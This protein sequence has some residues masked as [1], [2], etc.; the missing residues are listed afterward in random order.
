MKQVSNLKIE[1][2]K[3]ILETSERSGF[4]NSLTFKLSVIIVLSKVKKYF[5][6][7]YGDEK[8]TLLGKKISKLLLNEEWTID[9][10]FKFVKKIRRRNWQFKEFDKVI[11]WILSYNLTDSSEVDSIT[12]NFIISK[13]NPH[14][15][16][17]YLHKLGIHT[18]FIP[19]KEQTL[20]EL[21]ESIMKL[22]SENDKI[23]RYARK[24][25]AEVL[26]IKDVSKSKFFDTDK[27]ISEWE[28]SDILNWWSAFKAYDNKS[29][30]SIIREAISVIMR[31][32]KLLHDY[33][34]RFTQIITILILMKWS[35]SG[36]L[37]QVATGEGK[38]LIVAMLATLK[39]LQGHTVDIVTSA[40]HL[41][42]R[43]AKEMESFYALFGL[44]VGDNKSMS[45]GEKEWYSK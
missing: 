43:D 40:D 12:L 34:P 20:D 10:I 37:M 21:I 22:N 13:I 19:P 32:N 30:N 39:W 2:W 5:T 11:D 44:T 23:R 16:N 3:M 9:K 8:W 26:K 18:A 25:K 28:R 1:S 36:I 6:D 38:S 4:L 15:W 27:P 29:K 33:Y 24:L 17:I 31:G 35:N 45:N 7:L 41:A 42:E 14:D